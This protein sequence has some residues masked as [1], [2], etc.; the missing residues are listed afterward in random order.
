M[1]VESSEEGW[2]RFGGRIVKRPNNLSLLGLLG[3]RPEWVVGTTFGVCE[4]DRVMGRW[5]QYTKMNWKV[6]LEDHSIETY[7]QKL[8]RYAQRR[9]ADRG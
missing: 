1:T 7:C 4:F 9:N 6:G 2:E 8:E 3:Q 5:G